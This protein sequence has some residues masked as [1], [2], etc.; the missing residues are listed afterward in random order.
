MLIFNII[1]QNCK[2]VLEV[3][4]II[5]IIHYMAKASKISQVEFRCTI[6]DVEY[7]VDQKRTRN[8]RKKSILKQKKT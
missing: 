2:F 5:I 7:F 6:D 1:M 8:N 3:L 4:L